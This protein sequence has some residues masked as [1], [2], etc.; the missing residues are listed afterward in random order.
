M[1]TLIVC[2]ALTVGCGSEAQDRIR[3]VMLTAD[4]AALEGCQVWSDYIDCSLTDSPARA[5]TTVGYMP[6]GLEAYGECALRDI[7]LNRDT[8]AR[9]RMDPAFVFAHE[10]G[11]RAGILSHV[12]GPALMA[13]DAAGTWNRMELAEADRA[14]M[15]LLVQWNTK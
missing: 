15:E 1:K 8:I 5:N 2:L 14:V 9:D 13:E 10:I 4:P 12:D 7:Q 3:L 11:H 6:T